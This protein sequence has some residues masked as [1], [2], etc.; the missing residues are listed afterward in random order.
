VHVRGG[1]GGRGI[2]AGMISVLGRGTCMDKTDAL[3]TLHRC[4]SMMS[5]GVES[6]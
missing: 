3:L 4:I 2:A 5:A 6:D 1:G